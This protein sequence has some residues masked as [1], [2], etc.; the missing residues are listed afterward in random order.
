MTVL[1]PGGTIGI[2]GGGQLA[3]MLA[4]AGAPMGLHSHIFDPAERC[5][6]SLVSAAQT[7]AD[8]EDEAALIAFAEAVDV[9]TFEFE[10]VPAR[11]A[12][13]LAA[14]VPVR[15]G[16]RALAV[17]QDRLEEKTFI[18]QTAG[19]APFARVDDLA[20]L[21][22]AID[23]IGTPA[24][25]KTRRMGY[26]GKG[27]VKITGK[28]QAAAA[29]DAIA[30]APGILEGFV[31]F[32]RE[33]SVVIA[34]GLDGTVQA[35]DPVE[36]IHE[37][38]IL[39]K[40]IAPA[41]LGAMVKLDAVATAGRIVEALEYIG[42]LAVEYFLMA[43]G[44]LVVNEIAPR[45]HNSGHWTIEACE[46]SQFAQQ[47]R[48]VAGW[49]VIDPARH[50]DAVMHNLI[51]DAI[52]DEALLGKVLNNPR[53]HWHDYGKREARPGR[54]MGHWTETFDLGTDLSER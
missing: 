39:S 7:V 13:I 47:M 51:G 42:V 32:E 2:L 6:A 14:H 28:S 20:S 18:S 43:D 40:T 23:E 12:E 36:N 1:K 48:A 46:T 3:R 35:F 11:T 41:K 25:L 49:P 21:E 10:N 50:A 31:P 27:Q 54:K 45:V 29:L 4:L 24:V 34:R 22:A 5:P 53:A 17:A 16:P 52:N 19:V 38:H 15:P 8:Y 37:N 30:H 26:D 9:V 33:I 44:T